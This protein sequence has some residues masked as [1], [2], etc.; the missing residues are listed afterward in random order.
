MYTA[1][2]PA[3][4]PVNVSQAQMYHMQQH[5]HHIQEVNDEDLNAQSE[6]TQGGCLIVS[7]PGTTT[8]S[9]NSAKSD[10]QNKAVIADK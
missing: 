2:Q 10:N 4:I 6:E 7:S 3:Y 8:S 5:Q 9:G 1:Q